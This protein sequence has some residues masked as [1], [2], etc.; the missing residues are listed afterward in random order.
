VERDG[1]LLTPQEPH[2]Q[3]EARSVGDS[4]HK[5]AW[6]ITFQESKSPA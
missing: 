6:T 2:N 3:N 1:E 4:W 5:R